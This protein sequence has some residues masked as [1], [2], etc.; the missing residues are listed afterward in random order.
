MKLIRILNHLFYIDLREI[1]GL[2]LFLQI[3]ELDAN[4]AWQFYFA[5]ET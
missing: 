1:Y 5:K 2:I 3:Q 4:G